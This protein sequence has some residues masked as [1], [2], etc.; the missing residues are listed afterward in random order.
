VAHQPPVS[1]LFAAFLGYNPLQHLIGPHALASIPAGSRAILTSRSF[2]PHRSR[3]PFRTGLHE[4][5]VFAIV[6]CL[7]A[8]AASLMRGGRYHSADEAGPRSR[9]RAPL[10]WRPAPVEEQHAS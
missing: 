10:P 3:G 1:I 5:F 2:F 8:A 9:A 7:I 4:T 6:A